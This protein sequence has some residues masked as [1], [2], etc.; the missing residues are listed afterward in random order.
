VWESDKKL[1]LANARHS[2]GKAAST[3]S[4]HVERHNTE[5]NRDGSSRHGFVTSCNSR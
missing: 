1:H 4:Q 3:L 2:S 5:E